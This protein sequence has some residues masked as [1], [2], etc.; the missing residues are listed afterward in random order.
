MRFIYKY[1]TAAPLVGSGRPRI[2]AAVAAVGRSKTGDGERER[3]RDR[4]R[5]I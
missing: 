2:T 1:I 5:E 4:L 3:E